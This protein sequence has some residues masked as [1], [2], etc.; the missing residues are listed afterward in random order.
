LYKEKL[1]RLRSLYMGQLSRINYLLQ[2]KRR[3]FLHDWQA[4]GGTKEKAGLPSEGISKHAVA[5]RN[6]RKRVSEEGLLERKQKLR[7]VMITLELYT[8]KE[9]RDSNR[10]HYQHLTK[11][12]QQLRTSHTCTCSTVG[13][14]QMSMPFTAKCSKRILF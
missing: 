7:R 3:H 9:L 14:N 8:K 4:A 12:Q 2:E 6:Y 10:S 5:Y 1:E 11:L 13:C